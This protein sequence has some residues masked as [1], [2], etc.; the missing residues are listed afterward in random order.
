MF[1]SSFS[2]TLDRMGEKT[3][4]TL[5]PPRIACAFLALLD[6]VSVASVVRWCVWVVVRRIE[7]FGPL[8][9]CLG[10]FWLARCPVSDCTSRS[11]TRYILDFPQ[12][13]PSF[14]TKHSTAS[15]T[16]EYSTMVFQVHRGGSN[17]MS[18]L[19][20]RRRGYTV[21]QSRLS[22]VC[23]YVSTLTDPSLAGTPRSIA[24]D[25]SSPVCLHRDPH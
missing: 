9:G 16:H 2:V 6:Y 20:S 22:L 18:S 7:V 3:S 11:A 17:P 10:D 13:S 12:S 5:L 25:R 23:L 19:S 15:P 1:F 4:K 21:N 14:P 8:L 24:S